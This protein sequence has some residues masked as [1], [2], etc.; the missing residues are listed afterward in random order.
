MINH[1][2]KGTRSL[3]ACIHCRKAKIKCTN[4]DSILGCDECE[5]R[6][7]KCIMDPYRKKRGP[8]PKTIQVMPTLQLPNTINFD[9]KVSGLTD[10]GNN[11]VYD[12]QL[13]EIK[14]ILSARCMSCVKGK[15]LCKGGTPGLFKCDRCQKKSTCIFQCTACYKKNKDKKDQLPQCDHC[16]VISED[17]PPESITSN[18]DIITDDIGQKSYLRHYN[19]NQKIEITSDLLDAMINSYKTINPTY[20][21]PTCFSDDVSELSNPHS[22][23]EENYASDLSEI[24]FTSATIMNTYGPQFN[25]YDNTYYPVVDSHFNIYENVDQ[26]YQPESSIPNHFNAFTSSL[27]LSIT[28]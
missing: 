9:S 26:Y 17:L 20:I 7:L 6:Q 11:M 1:K 10:F 18:Y 4:F 16:N 2:P 25:V 14:P 23:N 24:D 19:C 21:T 8:K 28:N 27:P 12:I 13:S 3:T 22:Q 15:K 5:K